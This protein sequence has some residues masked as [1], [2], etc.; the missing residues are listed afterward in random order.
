MAKGRE[1]CALEEL[2]QWKVCRGLQVEHPSDTGETQRKTIRTYCKISL[3]VSV[4]LWAG[5]RPSDEEEERVLFLRCT[6]VPASL[7]YA[8]MSEECNSSSKTHPILQCS[9]THILHICRWLLCLDFTIELKD[10][11]IQLF[12]TCTLFSSGFLPDLGVPQR[13]I[14]VFSTI[15]CGDFSSVFICWYS[16]LLLSWSVFCSN[17]INLHRT[18]VLSIFSMYWSALIY[19]GP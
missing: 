7:S 9:Q 1:T 15:L 6:V 2:T 5:F 10:N 16:G 14:G 4:K 13:H 18:C 17:S 11:N 12:S 8:Y 19:C 3:L